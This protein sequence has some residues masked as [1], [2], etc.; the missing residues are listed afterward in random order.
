MKLFLYSV[1]KKF[2]K[3]SAKVQINLSGENDVELNLAYQIKNNDMLISLQDNE[4]GEIISDK[5][6]QFSSINIDDSN[7]LKITLKGPKFSREITFE[8]ENEAS[9][10]FLTIQKIA[11]LTQL[12]GEKRSLLITIMPQ[13]AGV[14]DYVPLLGFLNKTI[15]TTYKT[16]KTIMKGKDLEVPKEESVVEADGF[17][18]GYIHK[19]IS[20]VAL[21][22]YDTDSIND[23]SKILTADSEIHKIDFSKTSAAESDLDVLRITESLQRISSLTFTESQIYS[24]WNKFL[25]PR[26]IQM[27]QLYEDYQKIKTQWT[28]LLKGQWTHSF[29]LRSFVYN[30]ETLIKESKILSTLPY[31]RIAFDVLISRMYCFFYFSLRIN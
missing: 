24:I 3:M 2:I 1:F 12:P 15:S 16:V 14:T 20:D 10:F 22:E 17:T 6:S 7:A 26:G 30:S 23:N 27:V 11:K 8:K 18:L 31:N 9:D 13:Q 29:S 5:L 4:G 19:S 28:T 21:S 25:L